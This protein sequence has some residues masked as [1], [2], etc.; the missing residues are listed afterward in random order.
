MISGCAT[1]SEG[2]HGRL[3]GP[4]DMGLQ[5]RRCTRSRWTAGRRRRSMS[6]GSRTG[7]E[8]SPVRGNGRRHACGWWPDRNSPTVSIATHTQSRAEPP[9][10]VVTL[11]ATAAAGRGCRG[12]TCFGVVSCSG[13][14]IPREKWT[15]RAVFFQGRPTGRRFGADGP[16]GLAT[17]PIG[18]VRPPGPSRSGPGGSGPSGG[19][20]GPRELAASPYG[21]SVRSPLGPSIVVV[22]SWPMPAARRIRRPPGRPR[23]TRPDRVAASP[24]RAGRRSD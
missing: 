7:W 22:I 2:S 10:A 17:G 13:I 3:I 8:L 9:S 15:R 5:P 24:G 14:V 12:R 16:T 18:S 19:T 1:R 6:T 21:F 20:A 11:T 4:S 23:A